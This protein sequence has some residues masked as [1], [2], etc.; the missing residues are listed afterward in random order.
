[1][2]SRVYEIRNRQ[3]NVV[4]HCLNIAKALPLIDY[5]LYFM[6]TEEYIPHPIVNTSMN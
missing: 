6:L 3:M 1:M 5:S 2:D 4:G